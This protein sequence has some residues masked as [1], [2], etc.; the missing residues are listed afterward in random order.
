[1]KKSRFS[2]EQIVGVLKEA[3]AGVAGKD[4]GR[5]LGVS[6]ATFYHW[7]AHDRGLAGGGG[8]GSA[9]DLV[10]GGCTFS[11]GGR[12]PRAET[13][14]GWSTTS[15]CIGSTGKKGWPCGVR[16]ASAFGRQHAC[17]WQFRL[18]PM[19]CGPWTTRTTSFRAGGNSGR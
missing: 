17:R 7:Q 18:G 8:P 2:E 4:L 5:R 14:A 11:C 13:F 9:R 12:G 6:A 19:K 10:I 15:G 3:E 1:M 16:D